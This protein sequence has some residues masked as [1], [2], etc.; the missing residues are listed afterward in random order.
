MDHLSM[1]AVGSS[2]GHHVMEEQQ[3]RM[4]RY[5]LCHGCGH[6]S[7]SAEVFGSVQVP[8]KGFANLQAALQ[9]LVAPEVL[10]G[11]SKYNC[12]GCQSEQAASL[13]RYFDGERRRPPLE[14]AS[15]AAC[16]W[17]APCLTF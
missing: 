15:S 6:L 5:V 2:L 12:S 17:S 14:P 9:G 11:T 1:T 8:I 7:A 4:R 10:D 16:R 3:G 13:G